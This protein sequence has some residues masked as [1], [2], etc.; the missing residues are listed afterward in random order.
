M[1]SKQK[2]IHNFN[3]RFFCILLAIVMLSLIGSIT[4]Y[5]DTGTS[6][7]AEHSDGSYTSSGGK[8]YA[9][10]SRSGG[11][12]GQGVLI[13]LLERD[14]GGAV[15]GTTPKAYPCSGSMLG[16]ELH[17][18]DKY[19]RYPEVTS[20]EAGPIQWKD[21]AGR[22]Q[23]G[24]F[25][26][27]STSS[28][29]AAI[30]AWLKTPRGDGTNGIW[31]VQSIWGDAVATRFTNEEIVLVA[32]PIVAVQFSEYYDVPG[33]TFRDG[34]SVGEDFMTLINF[35]AKVNGLSDDTG[36]ST[37]LSR[38]LDESVNQM[39]NLLTGDHAASTVRILKDSIISSLGHIAMSVNGYYPLGEVYAGTPKM[40]ASYYAGLALDNSV[41]VPSSSTLKKAESGRKYYRL[42]ANAATYIPSTSTICS[43][44]GFDLWPTGS[45]VRIY[46]PDGNLNSK[47]IG[48]LAMLAFTEDGEG[49]YTYTYDTSCGSTPGKAPEYASSVT[50]TDPSLQRSYTIIKAY[51]TLNT[52]TSSTSTYINDGVYTRED[53]IGKILIEDEPTYTVMDW[54]TTST[55]TATVGLSDATRWNESKSHASIMEQ[56]NSSLASP[57]TLPSAQKYLYVLL[58]CTHTSSPP[59]DAN[60]T[61]LE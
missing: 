47:S 29:V 16:Y 14:G 26:K 9:T 17:A 33:L 55:P 2:T 35:R 11:Y 3:L 1:V 23:G 57:I 41:F 31:M 52:S 4:V 30:K 60:Y 20:W 21:A 24:G 44:A 49:D 45:N 32:E 12:K 22:A 43:N 19:N 37:D 39:Q 6:V 50:S 42:S 61:L 54:F 7:E 5:A 59:T 15:A 36:V 13:Y 38:K 51:R 8:W 34:A 25:M 28:N 48:M 56:G 10:Y 18:Q 27:N 46:H 40:V 58:E 53:T